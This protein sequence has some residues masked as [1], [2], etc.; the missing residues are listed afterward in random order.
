M[1]VDL[2]NLSYYIGYLSPTGSVT[3]SND[4]RQELYELLTEIRYI[5]HPYGAE[6]A[7]NLVAVELQ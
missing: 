4:H 3:L 5:V 6:E 7:V 1:N 2:V